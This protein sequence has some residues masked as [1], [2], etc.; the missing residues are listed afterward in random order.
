MDIEQLREFCLAL[1]GTTEGLKWGD[2]L[3]FMIAEKIYIITSLDDSSF[4]IKCDP[5]EFDALVGREG[6]EQAAHMAKRQWVRVSSLQVLPDHE[7]MERIKKSRALVMSK[8]TKKLQ[9]QYGA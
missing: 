1:P 5:E 6:I 4:S 2:H 3:C 8:L 7:L 9:A